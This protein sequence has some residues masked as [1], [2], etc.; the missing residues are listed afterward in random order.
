MLENNLAGYCGNGGKYHD[1]ENASEISAIYGEIAKELLS[2]IEARETYSHLK[3]ILYDQNFKTYEYQIPFAELPIPFEIKSLR[4]PPQGDLPSEI[5]SVTKVEIYPAS[6]TK[7][8][9]EV[10]GPLLD[11]WEA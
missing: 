11:M 4:I 3:V 7:Y 9:R 5:T 1:V 2:Y 10:V 8:D 6:Y